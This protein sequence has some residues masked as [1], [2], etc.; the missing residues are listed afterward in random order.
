MIYRQR[1]EG[2]IVN[3]P[4]V[5]PATATRNP[6]PVRLRDS[7]GDEWTNLEVSALGLEPVVDEALRI[8]GKTQHELSLGLQLVDGLN[9]FMDL[10]RVAEAGVI[11]AGK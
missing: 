6:S 4:G 8:S 1:R 7:R 2:N 9:S 3:W 5:T 11:N 10:C